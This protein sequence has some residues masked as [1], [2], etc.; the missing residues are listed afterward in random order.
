MVVLFILAVAA[1]VAAVDSVLAL[2]Y[3]ANLDDKAAPVVPQSVH[4]WGAVITAGAIFVVSLIHIAR[5]GGGGA[6]V[7][8][9]AGARRL[10][11]DTHDALERRLLNIVEE[12]SIA[13]GV[14]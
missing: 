1:V 5:L 7:A 14:R 3:L 4:V 8:A 10:E 12:M 13:S 11:P 6:V 2:I 9:M